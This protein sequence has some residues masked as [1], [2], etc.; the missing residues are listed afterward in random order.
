MSTSAFYFPR[1]PSRPLAGNILV[2]PIVSIGNISQLASSLLITSLELECIGRFDSRDLVPAVGGRE[3]GLEGITTPLE[4]YGHEGFEGFNVV[5]R[6]EDFIA[7][8]LAFITDSQFS[9]ILFLSGVDL[10]NRTDAQMITPTYHIVPPNSPAWKDTPLS[11]IS[12]LPIPAYTSPVSQNPLAPAHLESTIPFIPAG[13]LT[14]RIL[15][16]LPAAWDIPTASILQFVTEGDN[17]SDAFLMATAI[18]KV[19]SLDTREWKQP[20][21][22]QQGLF[23]TPQDQTLYG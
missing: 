11:T 3:D 12:T 22:W 16:S 13:G 9:A 18:S 2:V 19:L 21:S 4:L 20:L 6:K 8:L 10:S 14:R 1:E 17:R 15:S 23:G 5:D 7:K